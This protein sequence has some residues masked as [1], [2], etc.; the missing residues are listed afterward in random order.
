MARLRTLVLALAV[1][2]LVANLAAKTFAYQGDVHKSVR[3]GHSTAK[4]QQLERN[5]ASWSIP[6]AVFVPPLWPEVSA[7]A[8][9]P[10]E[11]LLSADPDSCLFT[12]PPP[13]C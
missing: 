5:P 1:L 4:R 13:S 10:S 7:C 2:S 6:V 11:P 8:P 9:V 3:S 12:R